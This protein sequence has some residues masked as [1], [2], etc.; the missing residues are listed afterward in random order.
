MVDIVDLTL[1]GSSIGKQ[2]PDKDLDVNSDGTIDIMDL[3]IVAKH[4]G[5]TYDYASIQAD[6]R[7]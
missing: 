1:V 6:L 7:P 5:E 4:F 3:A 2:P